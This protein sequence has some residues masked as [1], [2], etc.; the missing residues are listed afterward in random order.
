[1]T[2]AKKPAPAKAPAKAPAAPAKAPAK[3]PVVGPGRAH[4]FSSHDG[5]QST[6][7]IPTGPTSTGPTPAAPA[8]AVTPTVDPAVAAADASAKK[9]ADA[10]I[11][12]ILQQYGLES[13]SNWAWTEISQ[14]K[15]PAEVEQDLRGTQQFKDRFPAIGLREQYNLT[16]PGANM[17]AL[18]PGE[19]VSYE[20]SYR[21]LLHNAGLPQGFL[22][23]PTHVTKL[24]AGDVSIAEMT[25]RVEQARVATFELNPEAVNRLQ[26]MHGIS[27]GSGALTALMLDPTEAEPLLKR[28]LLAAQIGAQADRTGYAGLNNVTAQTL[29]QNG[30]SEAQAQSGFN[31][32]QHDNPLFTGLPGTQE[33]DISQSEQLAAVFDQNA[34]DQRLVEDRRRGRLSQFADNGAGGFAGTQQG[35]SGLGSAPG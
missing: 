34:E 17:P 16:H 9:D 5:T 12:G 2:A 14:N 4:P 20:K 25:Q 32:L 27:P 15:S 8:P 13:L 22:D 35:L 1:M 26:Q 33:R 30:V 10:Y 21:Q 18:S 3:A 29:A 31:Q 28:D 11:Q 19:Y 23:D 7:A 24:L 6:P